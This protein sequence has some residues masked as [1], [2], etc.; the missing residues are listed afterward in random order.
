MAQNPLPSSV[1]G[2]ITGQ[3]QA[4]SDACEAL[5]VT[6]VAL[7]FLSTAGGD[8][9]MHL[10]VYTQDVLR[11]AGQSALV[12]KA[13]SRCQLKHAIALW[14][15][16]AAHKS[17]QLLRLKR[18]PFGDLSPQYKEDLSPEDARLLRAFLRQHGLDAFLLE[19]H[20]MMV[21]KLG[22][23]QPEDGFNPA[24]S[25]R[26]TLLCYLDAKECEL[27]GLEAQFPEQILM[28]SCVAVWKAAATLKQERQV[29]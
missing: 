4:Y 29:R 25:L 6:E 18:E 9:S 8:P 28:S 19:L 22:G 13:L 23:L 21:L 12:V 17:E 11:M 2:A 15:L 27:P 16:L 10:N 26:D 3:L 14:Q 1:A 7:G 24:W 20:E 5:S